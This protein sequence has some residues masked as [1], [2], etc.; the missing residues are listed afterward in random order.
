MAPPCVFCVIVMKRVSPISSSIVPILGRFGISGGGCGIWPAGMLPLWWSLGNGGAGPL[1][2]PP[3]FKPL[4]LLG[5]PL[6][7]RTFGWREIG[8]FFR[9]RC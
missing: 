1:F 9:I 2:L 4:G 3:F 5:L 8:G 7:S 6:L